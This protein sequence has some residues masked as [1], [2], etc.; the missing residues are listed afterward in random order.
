MDRVEGA[1]CHSYRRGRAAQGRSHAIRLA[2]EGAEHHRRSTC[3]SKV[4]SGFR[5]AGRPRRTGPE[6]QGRRGAGAPLD[7]R[8]TWPTSARLRGASSRRSIPGVAQLGLRWTIV[9]RKQP[10]HGHH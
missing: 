5:T 10:T 4:E 7:R 3:A 2:Q 9:P 6:V 1:R 8:R